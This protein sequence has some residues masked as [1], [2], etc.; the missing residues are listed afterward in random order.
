MKR[1]APS[2]EKMDR[3]HF[4]EVVVIEF[5]EELLKTMWAELGQ[6]IDPKGSRA[7]LRHCGSPAGRV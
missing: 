1:A 7:K 6:V 2:L 5:H 3:R 4:R